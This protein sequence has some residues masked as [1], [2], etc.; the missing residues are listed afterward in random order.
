MMMEDKGDMA[1]PSERAGGRCPEPA[2]QSQPSAL[3]PSA[4]ENP[5]PRH[6][7]EGDGGWQDGRLGQAYDL[8]DTVIRARGE[9]AFRHPLLASIEAYDIEGKL[10]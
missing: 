1:P 3:I 5:M 6:L 2:A 9:D 4:L 10:T 7:Y 8:I